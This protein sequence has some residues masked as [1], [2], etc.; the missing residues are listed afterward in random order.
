MKFGIEDRE[1]QGDS[2]RRGSRLFSVL[3]RKD[4]GAGLTFAA[5]LVLFSLAGVWLDGHAGTSPLFLLIG[6][7]MGAVGGFVHLVET[8]SPGTLFP[9]RRRRAG[10]P[11]RDNDAGKQDD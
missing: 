4:V 11:T 3:G 8:V 10:P 9:S 5:S 7:A 6:L 2:G 1:G